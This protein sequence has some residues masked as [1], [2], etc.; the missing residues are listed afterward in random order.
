MRKQCF[1]G[2]IYLFR[3]LLA[4]TC[5]CLAAPLSSFQAQAALLPLP[6]LSI[7]P[8]DSLSSTG[9]QGGPFNPTTITYRVSNIGSGIFD[10]TA[11]SDRDWVTLIPTNGQ[12]SATVTVLINEKANA[13]TNSDV[14]TITFGGNAGRITRTVQLTL[15]TN[16]TNP[17]DLS[18]DGLSDLL[19]QDDMGD[20]GF[21]SMNKADLIAGNVFAPDH[22]PDPVGKVVGHADFTG[23]G[24]RDLVLESNDGSLS[25]WELKGIFS[26]ASHYLPSF[27][28]YGRLAGIRDIDGNGKTDLIFQHRDGAVSA[29]MMNGRLVVRIASLNSENPVDPSWKVVGTGDF[30]GTGKWNLA[31]QNE[32]GELG[33]W[34]MDG[35]K[36]VA[37]HF[38]I[39]QPGPAWR[40]VAVADLDRDGKSDLILENLL[41]HAIGVWFMNG[42]TLRE[43]KLLN[44]PYVGGSWSIV[45]PK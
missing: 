38:V 15:T 5:L 43:P 21:W 10:W 26:P 28:P 40:V 4:A 29:L 7:S 36:L 2:C 14:A 16:R 25:V 24:Q 11:L 27:G 30:Y 37:P 9:T 32:D 31:W 8:L 18:G 45:G 41:D 33:I 42:F 20:V 35:L 3:K 19:L 44:P 17:D 23:D 34:D 13:L 39:P 12:D 22:A 1:S 6:L